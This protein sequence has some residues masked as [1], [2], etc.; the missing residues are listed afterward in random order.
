[1]QNNK[2]INCPCCN[3]SNSIVAATLKENCKYQRFKEFSAKKYGGSL[4]HLLPL[5]N[6]AIRK[7]SYCGHLWYETQPSQAD[8]IKMY[9]SGVKI[10]INANNSD[11]DRRRYILSHLSKF[12]KF[13]REQPNK[14]LDF[15]SGSGDWAKIAASLGCQV[16]A[17][18]PAASRA[19]DETTLSY[20]TVHKLS[21]IMDESFDLVNMEQVLEHVPSPYETMCEVAKLITPASVV[22]ISVPN[23]NRAYEKNT[24]WDDWPF[25]GKT[26]H[27]MAPFEHL[28]GF[29]P[30]SFFCLMAECGFE[31][32][33][34]FDVF[35]VDFYVALKI[36]IT[37]YAHRFGS[38]GGYWRLKT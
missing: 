17:Y 24:F 15:G 32:L 20:R 28:H 22:R 37:R 12:V 38:T 16:V 26:P 35:K 7:C 18:E 21:D 33:P 25:N 6:I 5:D 14:M 8:L 27:T 29:T 34:L 1:M 23:V 2:I 19:E 3:S 9:N 30:H 4:E 13:Y 11:S 36:L 10:N 31:P